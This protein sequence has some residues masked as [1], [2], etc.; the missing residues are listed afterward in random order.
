MTVSRGIGSTILSVVGILVL[1]GAVVVVAMFMGNNA[2][3]RPLIHKTIELRDAS[4]PVDRADLITTIDDL[5]A[6]S[7]SDAIKDQW[8]RMLQCLATACPDVAYFD[9]ILVTVANFEEDIP[10][11]ALLINIV[12]TAKYW[13]DSENLLEF[14]KA[15]SIANEQI[16]DL[17]S[18]KANKLW[19]EIV[20]C[21]GVCPEKNDLYFDLIRTIV[22]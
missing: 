11:S 5:A 2:P 1:L 17:D 21:N 7:G 15:L 14:S 13:G 9:L 8:D 4:D 22:Q 20:D 3:I 12:A 10:E 6:Q 16:D 19:G 18:R